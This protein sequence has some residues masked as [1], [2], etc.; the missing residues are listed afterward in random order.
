MAKIG[1][2]QPCPCGSRRKYKKCHGMN[3]QHAPAPFPS[4]AAVMAAKDVQ[5][6]R[7]QGEGRPIIA[8]D[9]FGHKIVAV[10][11]RLFYS[12]NWKTFPDFLNHYIKTAM[13]AEWGAAEL[14]KPPGQRHPILIW[15][16]EVCAQRRQATKD[17]DTYST[18]L[19]GAIAAYLHLAYDLYTLEHNAEL[20][21]KLIERL[22]LAANF[23]GARYEVFVAATLIRA[24]F[25]LEFENEADRTRSH[26]EFTATFI[27]TKRRFSVEA[28]CRTGTGNEFRIG[29]QLS[30]ALA[31]NASHE[32]IVFI[33]INEPDDGGQEGIPQLLR[34]ALATL[35]KLEGKLINGKP[36]PKAYL[37][38]TNTPRHHHLHEQKFR[39]SAMAEGFQI[40]EFKLDAEFSSLREAIMARERHLEIFSLMKSIMDHSAIPI[41]F[42]GDIPELAFDEET[43]RLLIG[44]RYLIDGNNE[45]EQVGQLVE[46]S[47]LEPERKAYCVLRFPNGKSGIYTWPLTDAEMIAWKRHP[48]TFFGV[49]KQRDTH[50]HNALDLYDF[51]L[52]SYSRTPKARLLEFLA[53]SSDFIELNKLDQPSLASIYAE[54]CA[55]AAF[56]SKSTPPAQLAGRAG[57]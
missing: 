34:N 46:A 20:Q 12:K 19:T 13:G 56:S 18:P 10:K 3:S 27:Q 24:G 29:R 35:R 2:N 52:S 41:T 4:P 9:A 51:F 17:G 33:E 37:F 42:D 7:Q 32:R 36:R 16:E 48:D 25:E 23:E 1:R 53:G 50:A 40:P 38:V 8:A 43:P 11:S 45:P 30:R 28:K 47:V 21:K 5:R 39:C 44:N 15:Y 57:I 49:L 14:A 26:C 54:R 55:A 22:Q 31:K 6:R